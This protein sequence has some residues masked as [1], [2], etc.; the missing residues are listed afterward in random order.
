[1]RNTLKKI[2][3]E[4]EIDVVE[5]HDFKVASCSGICKSMKLI[6]SLKKHPTIHL[7]K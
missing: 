3:Q 7:P 5:S 6:P 4:K 2:K 1:M